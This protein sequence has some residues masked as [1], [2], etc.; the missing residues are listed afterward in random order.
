MP[1]DARRA[2][3]ASSSKH[4]SGA[5]SRY[6]KLGTFA[7]GAQRGRGELLWRKRTALGDPHQEFD[8]Y[9]NEAI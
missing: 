9:S 2:Q 8:L 3:V 1:D 6:T 5:G 7:G 4:C